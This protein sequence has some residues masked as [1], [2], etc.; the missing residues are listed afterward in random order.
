[1][2]VLGMAN[3]RM[4]DFFDVWSL[5]SSFEF[6]GSVL[7]DSIEATFARRRTEL[8]EAEPLALTPTFLEDAAKAKQWVAFLRRTLIQE[9]RSLTLSEVGV[10]LRA[11][12]LPLLR[13]VQQGAGFELRWS[14][15][16]LAWVRRKT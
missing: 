15:S 12:L 13:A 4:K 1:M 11:F 14:S 8:P 9:R 3:S 5:A 2:V 7:T 10:V 16:G 6:E